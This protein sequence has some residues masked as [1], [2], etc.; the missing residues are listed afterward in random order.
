MGIEKKPKVKRRTIGELLDALKEDHE[1]RGKASRANLSLISVVKDSFGD[2]MADSLTDEDITAYVARLRRQ[3]TSDKTLKN[4][5]QVLKQAF[6]KAKLAPPCCATEL[7]NENVRTGFLT[8]AQF[9]S[10]YSHLPEDLKDF[11]L[12]SYITGWR[13]GAITKLEWGDV[14]D[15]NVYLRAKHSKNGRPYFVPLAGELADLFERRKQARAIATATGTVLS[16][17]V[18][19]REGIAVADFDKSWATACKHSGCEGTL[20][21]DLRRS[22]ARNLI[23]AG[24]PRAVAK[25]ITGHETDSMFDRYNITSEAD[26]TD[27]VVRLNNY[28]QTE[29][30]KVVSIGSR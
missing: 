11:T 16:R 28:S 1:G 27:A 25:N 30:Q 23:R 4:H 15:G 22:A 19:H 8:R 14:R 2:R 18:F 5:L 20:F 6:T 17:L 9:D 24:V 7:K 13:K 29:R 3:K 10:L 12:F 21:H 26:L